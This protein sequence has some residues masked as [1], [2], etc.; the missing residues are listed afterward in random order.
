MLGER[1]GKYRV[2]RL[3][4]EGPGGRVFEGVHEDTQRRVAIKLARVVGPTANFEEMLHEAQSAAALSGPGVITLQDFG[5]LPDQ[6]QYLVYEYL[7]GPSLKQYLDARGPLP[8]IE[9]ALLGWRMAALL[10]SLHAQGSTHGD[11][12][13]ENF[14]VLA[15]GTSPRQA[16][17]KLLDFGSTVHQH[18]PETL[19]P[20]TRREAGTSGY[21][22]PELFL[23][24][25]PKPPSDVYSLAVILCE[26]AHG[27]PPFLGNSEMET[28]ALQR[29]NLTELLKGTCLPAPISL[30]LLQMLA[31]NPEERPL[32]GEVAARLE[33]LSSAPLRK[34]A[35]PAVPSPAG[36]QDAVLADSPFP[37]LH[38][39]D[40]SNSR[41]FFGRETETQE[42]LRRIGHTPLGLRRWL[43]IEGPSG[44]GKSSLVHAGIVPAI[45]AGLLDDGPLYWEIVN[46]RPGPEPIE[47]LAQTLAATELLGEAVDVGQ[48]SARLHGDPAA[49][50]EVLKR[51]LLDS[52]GL[53]LFVDQLEEL[54]LLAGISSSE[55]L[56]LDAALAT[57]LSDP[58]LPLFLITTVRSDFLDRFAAMPSL[59][60]LLNQ[61]SRY[62]LPPPGQAELLRAIVRPAKICGLEFSPGLPEEIAADAERAEASLPLLAHVLRALWTQRE[63][64]VLTREAYRRL[65]G[66]GGAL[67]RSADELLAELSAE[68]RERAR[69]LLLELVRPGR[70]AAPTRCIRTRQEVLDAQG[71]DEETM[72]ILARLSGGQDGGG[73][74]SASHPVPAIR[75]VV[76]IG[77]EHTEPAQHRVTLAHDALLQHWTTLRR[78]IRADQQ[79]LLRRD[80]V[81]SAARTWESA[82]KPAQEL[83]G[84]P[85]LAYLQGE[86]LDLTQAQHLR[87]ALSA[88]ARGFLE[89]ADLL[90]KRRRR[91]RR[92]MFT[93]LMTA[94][95]L[96]SALSAFTGE[97]YLLARGRLREAT[98]ASDGIVTAIENNLFRIPGA[99]AVGR[100]LLQQLSSLL[101]RLLVNAPDDL[102][103]LRCRAVVHFRSAELLRNRGEL[104]QAR[105]ESA[106][107][108]ATS[109]RLAA[110]YPDSREALEVLAASY[111]QLGDQ[112]K[113]ERKWEAARR[114][115]ED[116]LAV[117]RSLAARSQRESGN[118]LVHL[119]KQSI[120]LD[121]LG[122]IAIAQDQVPEAAAAYQEAYQLQEELLREDGNNPHYRYSASVVLYRL[123]D[124]Q[125]RRGEQ[126]EARKLYQRSKDIQLALLEEGHRQ[127]EYR[128]TLSGIAV[129]QGDTFVNADELENAHAYYQEAERLAENIVEN[130]PENMKYLKA[131]LISRFKVAQ[132]DLRLRRCAH[133]ETHLTAAQD[134]LARIHKQSSS[135]M[136]DPQLG[137][138]IEQVKQLAAT[139]CP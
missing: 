15:E 105:T 46:L 134:V 109:R 121:G 61:A 88:P 90:S 62:Y 123:G 3:L 129:R 98:V 94:L 25:P 63:Q 12:K 26:L 16:L 17:I 58:D 18:R 119:Q 40:E 35:S 125:H 36:A 103:A 45:R 23:G 11:L 78:W 30:L 135:L 2:T 113:F 138:A 51:S 5:I 49:L 128:R 33:R 44:A 54:F 1:I 72:R 74:A 139:P 13:P 127:P 99:E 92:A 48:L 97:E 85:A 31:E 87:T 68:G 112:E 75:L 116:A 80:E 50:C 95:F 39:F 108:V 107:A 14:F 100:E 114:A 34:T 43:Q 101:D 52:Q 53:L 76:V 7:S 67:A 136:I 71:R 122:D 22:S 131:L 102:P 111:L 19:Q 6:R 115:Y 20:D 126:A 24:E 93:G 89:A 69:R 96:V 124:V 65:G 104:G 56:L 27:L 66:V 57:A 91:Q 32:M 110:K 47:R 60:R 77:D 9:V 38:A 29:G 37:G 21:R 10:S 73:Q 118:R 133:R 137:D 41:Y 84:G 120:C 4:D 59:A 86:G 82:G 28:R 42:A 8:P 81:E 106:D 64:Q 79:M 132:S 117:E 55:L 83:P 70:G 130:E